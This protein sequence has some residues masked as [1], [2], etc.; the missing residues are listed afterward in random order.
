[1]SDAPAAEQN[2]PT[3]AEG[4]VAA[5]NCCDKANV[6]LCALISPPFDEAQAEDFPEKLNAADRQ[7][8]A[9]AL[10]AVRAAREA[11]TYV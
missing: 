2:Y 5:R 6:E 1:M 8:L 9:A 11:L 3:A 4:L 7:C 10:R